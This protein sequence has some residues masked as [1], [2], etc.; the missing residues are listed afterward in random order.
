[1]PLIRHVMTFIGETGLRSINERMTGRAIRDFSNGG[2]S[3]IFETCSD[4]VG[5]ANGR[6]S[7][8]SI[9]GVLQVLSWGRN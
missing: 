6:A 9:I 8:I 5:L 4:T 7:T 3:I 2:F 1:M